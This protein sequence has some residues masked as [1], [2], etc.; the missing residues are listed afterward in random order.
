MSK[1]FFTYT[2]IIEALTGLGLMM[3]PATIVRVLLGAELRSGLEIILAMVAGAAIFSIALLCWLSR[4]N[5]ESLV[6]PGVLLFYNFAVSLIF[7]YAALGLK[8]TGF[9]LWGVIAFHLLQTVL[10]GV[11]LKKQIQ[12]EN[13]FKIL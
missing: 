11:L 12:S 1:F 7:L 2:G 10:C 8:F 3:V 6:A 4:I 5:T 13:Q 9:P